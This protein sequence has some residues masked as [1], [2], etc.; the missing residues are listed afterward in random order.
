MSNVEYVYNDPDFRWAFDILDNFYSALNRKLK[1]LSI[2]MNSLL[3][4]LMENYY[5]SYESFIPG[6]F[7]FTT[8]FDIQRLNSHQKKQK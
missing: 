5:L 4:I 7:F 3:E 2:E 8:V 1:I 6:W